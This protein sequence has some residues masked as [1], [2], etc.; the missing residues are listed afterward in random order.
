[1]VIIFLW[2]IGKTNNHHLCLLWPNTC[3]L[4][5]S[6]VEILATKVMLRGVFCRWLVNGIKTLAELTQRIL[7]ALPPCEDTVRML[8]LWTR[9]Q[10]LT[11]ALIKNFQNWSVDHTLSSKRLSKRIRYARSRKIGRCGT[12]PAFSATPDRCYY[13]A[14]FKVSRRLKKVDRWQ[15]P[16]FSLFTF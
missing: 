8:Q 15:V 11:S 7:F 1:M 6:Y 4:L 14:S 16:L 9:K 12:V 10:A 13:S 2:K 5:H 3:V